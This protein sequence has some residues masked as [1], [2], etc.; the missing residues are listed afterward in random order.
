MTSGMWLGPEELMT[1]EGLSR[2]YRMK[3]HK[4]MARKKAKGDECA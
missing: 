1:P 4:D 2:P 3:C